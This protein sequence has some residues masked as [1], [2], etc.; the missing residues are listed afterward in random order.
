VKILFV[1]PQLDY[2]DHIS[3]S[4]L[5]AVAK[6]LGHETSFCNLNSKAYQNCPDTPDIFAYSTTIKHFEKICSFNKWMKQFNKN[7]IS[8]LGGSHATFAPETFKQSGMDYYC[9]GE[10]EGAFKDF[11]MDVDKKCCVS[12]SIPNL[13]SKTS[14]NPV[15]VRPLI[16]D[17]DSLPFPDRD[18]TLANSYLK[19]IPKKTFYTSRGCPYSCSYCANNHYNKMH[20]GQKIVR[21]F[22]VDRIIDE[23]KYVKSKYRCEFIKFGDDVFALKVDDWFREFSL[24]YK[25]QVNL[26]F[27]CFLRIDSVN[28]DLLKLLSEAGCH[29]VHLS[30]DSTN[31]LI[32]DCVLTRKSKLDTEEMIDT[33]KLIY[34]YGIKTWVNYMLAAP[35]S[36]LSDDVSTIRVSKA[37]KVSYT[38][39]SMT[40]PIKGTDLYEYCL[41]NGYIDKSY[42]GDM[43]N[44]TVRSVLKCFTNK[45]KDIR[46][47]VYLL[48]ALGV[49]LPYC[50][51][52]L[53]IFILN[54][55]KPN[56]F[57]EWVHKK[58][59]K[60]NIER[61]IYKLS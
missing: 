25:E 37:G 36:T 12:S 21:R 45:E 5:S 23:I 55:V 1:V 51:L 54:V 17:L 58:Y 34:S 4:Y 20:R 26:S 46:Y 38:H 30:I 11:L 19:D 9:V 52:R 10:G 18:L 50:F 53:F 59:Y 40:D 42:S 47:N 43:S 56:R 41:T 28:D 61:I 57:F 31:D 44:C 2:A 33:L 35:L 32:R 60:Y 13:I 48:G 22:S 16:K 15:S 3:I 39:Y 8:I 27:N 24:K 6:E 14:V 29:S 7:F 49:K